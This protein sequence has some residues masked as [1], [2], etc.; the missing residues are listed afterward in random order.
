MN[1]KCPVQPF[2]LVWIHNHIMDTLSKPDSEIKDD[3]AL[4]NAA[5][6]LKIPYLSFLGAYEKRAC[7]ALAEFRVIP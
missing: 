1:E 2:D 3:Y 4:R 6:Q 7:I 5:R